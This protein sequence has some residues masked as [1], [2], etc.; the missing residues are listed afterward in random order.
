MTSLSDA[1]ISFRVSA[2]GDKALNIGSL[3]ASNGAVGVFANQLMSS[4]SISANRATT[5]ARGQIVLQADG[6][7]EVGG[8]VTA[9]G[10]GAPGGEITILGDDIQL[11]SAQIDTTGTNGGKVLIGGEFQGG[12]NLQRA[13]RT[14]IDVNSVIHADALEQGNGGEIIVWS[15]QAT[16][17]QGRLTA[18]GGSISGNGG[19][20]ETSSRGSLQF[21]QP[22]DVSAT[23][24][25]P[26]TWLLDPED[27]VIDS[28]HADSIS[29]ALNGGS[30]VQVK[31]ADTGTGEGNISVNAP[32]RKTEGPDAALGL[33][34]HNRIDVN[35]PIESI[36]GKLSVSLK[37]GRDIAV[38]APV[39][40]NGG[41]Y[42]ANIVPSLLPA[43]SDIENEVTEDEPVVSTLEE[44]GS[45]E[46][47]EALTESAAVEA[48]DAADTTTSIELNENGISLDADINT[49]GGDIDINAGESGLLGINGS[50]ISSGDNAGSV[51]LLG[52]QVA[53]Y[54]AAR[55]AA[56][57]D[58]GGGEI[59][60]G[61][62]QQGLNPDV[63]NSELV[64]IDDTASVN[65]DG[66]G[67]A[68]G[69]R[70]IVFAEDT[71]IIKGQISA[72]GGES[73]GNGGFI[74]TSG[75]RNLRVENAPDASAKNGQAGNWLIDP[76]TITIADTDNDINVDLS[77][78]GITN[79]Y[80]TTNNDAII[81]VETI[82]NALAGGTNVEVVTANNS[83]GAGDINLIADI[84]LN[85]RLQASAAG[86]LALRAHNDINIRG[87][88][89]DSQPFG[90]SGDESI[91]YL[92][93][94]ANLDS[95][96]GGGVNIDA[97]GHSAISGSIPEND[98]TV[99]AIGDITISGEYL[100]IS[101][102][103]NEDFE[104]VRVTTDSALNID[105]TGDIDLVANGASSRAN[106]NSNG[107]GSE[108]NAEN[109]T[110]QTNGDFAYSDLR[111]SG[112][113]FPT[114]QQGEVNIRDTITL[115]GGTISG[116]GD[117]SVSNLIMRGGTING[118][119]ALETTGNVTIDAQTATSSFASGVGKIWN[120]GENSVVNWNGGTLR[121]GFETNNNGRF[122]ANSDDS[123]F[124]PGGDTPGFGVFN[125]NAS[126]EFIKTTSTCNPDCGA[127]SFES[128]ELATLDFVNQGL[129]RVE[130]GDLLFVQ[131]LGNFTGAQ[132]GGFTQVAGE[133]RLEG[134]NL[135]GEFR[136]D[137][138][139]PPG[140]IPDPGDLTFN[141]GT[142]SGGLT[143]SV[144]DGGEVRGN[145]IVDGANIAAG[146]S[147]GTLNFNGDLSVSSASSFTIELDGT[148]TGEFDVINVT[149]TATL[150]NPTVNVAF[151][152]YTP[153]DTNG[154]LDFFD[155]I[156]A[157]NLII[158]P[159]A[160]A[161]PLNQP[162]T[163]SPNVTP[164]IRTSR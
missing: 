63:P 163:L 41:S 112:S 25:S 113:N 50:V 14:D 137:N 36:S 154:A 124:G 100:N 146:Q 31:T 32:I 93:L 147:P 6:G 139:A 20:V 125:N 83:D 118:S 53:L 69:G 72:K 47:D 55:I 4:G 153:P 98:I 58:T 94:E 148:N 18:R 110:L 138:S 64:Y 76:D 133:T 37:A 132:P 88:I 161:L 136:L 141:G 61:G 35:A 119:G 34:A 114:P 145:T 164:N 103:N 144:S 21:G 13:S 151:L 111:Y 158:N 123:A 30:N 160:T 71:A 157:Q 70:V 129:V 44:P 3:T 81:G 46:I 77:S 126:G 79:T 24:G 80:A 108:I 140:T 22:A 134:G 43:E 48:T 15:E 130:E 159:G 40:T 156:T 150:N 68:S 155:V 57:S 29:T 1:N 152:G 87:S 28:A 127:T 66:I 97:T 49:D 26:G 17:S 142:L 90:V 116:G 42:S 131:D 149:G 82:I 102:G 84:D 92:I 120:I 59:L 128:F 45:E 38:N 52:N 60:I 23:N 67:N 91:A 33:I 89:Y 135:V 74:E 96:D 73:G 2:P 10:N 86:G 122:L 56:S 101:A 95:V 99:E 85:Q 106:L 5:N 62:D 7:T 75:K 8:S 107:T 162:T 78:D 19:L 51:K 12:G 109:L 143:E 9:T 65:A 104:A 39:N 117:M 121:L 105:V 16:N 11:T 27:I 54:E 115:D